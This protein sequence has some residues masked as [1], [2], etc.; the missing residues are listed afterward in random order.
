MQSI[1]L[2]IICQLHLPAEIVTLRN[3]VFDSHRKYFFN[4]E[5]YRFLD[6][7]VRYSKTLM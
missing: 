1:Y 3:Y 5:L 6:A 4:H 2:S 7:V